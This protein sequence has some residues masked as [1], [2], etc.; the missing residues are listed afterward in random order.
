MTDERVPTGVEGLTNS[1]EADRAKERAKLV[2]GKTT[3]CQQ[4]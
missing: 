1:L 3:F 2:L 4:F